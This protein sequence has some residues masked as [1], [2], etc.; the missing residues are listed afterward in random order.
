MRV[1]EVNFISDLGNGMPFSFRKL[2]IL[3]TGRVHG[4]NRGNANEVLAGECIV[5]ALQREFESMHDKH[6]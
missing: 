6:S 4:R 1:T 5:M 2:T 3:S